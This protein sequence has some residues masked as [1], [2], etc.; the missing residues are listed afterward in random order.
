MNPFVKTE[1]KTTIFYQVDSSPVLFG[2]SACGSVAYADVQDPLE[3][4]S[5]EFARNFREQRAADFQVP[6]ENIRIISEEEYLSLTNEDSCC[7]RGETVF[8]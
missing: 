5:D 7:F 8:D 1:I 6:F 4:Y 2:A 3:F